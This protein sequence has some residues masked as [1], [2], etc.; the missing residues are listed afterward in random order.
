MKW[1]IILFLSPLHAFSEFSEAQ[2][3]AYFYHQRIAGIPP[4]NS[5]LLQ[6]SEIIESGGGSE[7]SLYEAALIATENENLINSQLKFY[8]SDMVNRSSEKTGESSDS[9]YLMLGLIRDN[10]DFREVLKTDNVYKIS[11]DGF[12]YTFPGASDGTGDGNIPKIPGDPTNGVRTYRPSFQEDPIC[13]NSGGSGCSMVTVYD[14][15]YTNTGYNNGGMLSGVVL[16]NIDYSLLNLN[17]FLFSQ[18]FISG[19]EDFNT[20]LDPSNNGGTRIRYPGQNT[21]VSNGLVGGIMTTDTFAT[22]FY[23]GGTNRRATQYIFRNFLCAEFSEVFDTTVDTQFIRRDVDRFP[24]GDINTYLNYCIGCHAGQDSLG[25]AFVNYNKGQ[26]IHDTVDYVGNL[27]LYQNKLNT[28]INFDHGYV[29]GKHKKSD[30]HLALP[31]DVWKNLWT[32]NHNKALG[33]DSSWRSKALGGDEP[34]VGKG[35]KEFG[36]YIGKSNA[37]NICMVKK[38]F[39]FVCFNSIAVEDYQEVLSEFFKTNGYNIKKLIAKAVTFCPSANSG[40]QE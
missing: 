40:G 1:L 2:K 14:P 3:L 39:E 7:E 31:D 18:E 35:L 21:L 38:M 34:H 8:L 29:V 6:M 5:V 25:R 15:T 23:N 10:I 30:S 37:F 17:Q 11:H 20:L 12:K 32:R 27:P 36:D 28:V 9:L 24:N 33:F 16:K 13:L 26:G 22:E 4:S 19:V